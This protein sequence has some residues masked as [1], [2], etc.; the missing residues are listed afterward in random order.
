MIKITLDKNLDKET[1]LNFFEL[2][3]GGVDFGEKIIKRSC[4]GDIGIEHLFKW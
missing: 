4:F 3:A 1:F 2:K